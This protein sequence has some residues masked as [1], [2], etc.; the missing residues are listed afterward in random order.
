M[1]TI[2]YDNSDFEIVMVGHGSL[3]LRRCKGNLPGKQTSLINFIAVDEIEKCENGDYKLTTAK[4]NILVDQ[5]QVSVVHQE[6]LNDNDYQRYVSKVDKN[7]PVDDIQIDSAYEQTGM[8]S[9]VEDF[10]KATRKDTV[11]S[12]NRT[13]KPSFEQSS[14]IENE[15]QF[16]ASVRKSVE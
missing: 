9:S 2:R 10:K 12:S 5:S 8:I 7:I 15:S 3:T 1:E 16:W 6:V 11:I 13:E 4:G 14:V